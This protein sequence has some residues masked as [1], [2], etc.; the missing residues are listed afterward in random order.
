MQESIFIVCSYVY[1]Y[2]HVYA[3]EYVHNYMLN[4][5]VCM[6]LCERVC[7]H[8][9]RIFTRTQ[10]HK[11]KTLLVWYM[12]VCV[13][14]CIHIHILTLYSST[15]QICGETTVFGGKFAHMKPVSP[16]L[17][18][19]RPFSKSQDVFIVGVEKG[20]GVKSRNRDPQPTSNARC[21]CV[22]VG[23]CVCPSLSQPPPPSHALEPCHTMW[24]FTAMNES[25]GESC[26]TH[27]I[28]HLGHDSF[29]WD[30]SHVTLV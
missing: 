17:D 13:C 9:N 1:I 5:C 18:K 22:C 21:V 14:T 6:H 27:M 28:F 25:M 11:P 15:P 4:V 29:I 3:H 2:T 24:H 16:A 19:S 26:H 10:A 8:T 7:T 12:Y 30:M 23:V 20:E